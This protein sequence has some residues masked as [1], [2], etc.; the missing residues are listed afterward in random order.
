MIY[1]LQP[2]FRYIH[3]KASNLYDSLQTLRS[4]VL[5]ARSSSSSPS[6][7]RRLRR[8]N[9]SNERNSWVVF[10]ANVACIFDA[11]KSPS[12]RSFSLLAAVGGRRQIMENRFPA[13]NAP[14]Y[15]HIRLIWSQLL[16]S[17]KTLEKVAIAKK[18]LNPTQIND[19]GRYFWILLV[20]RTSLFD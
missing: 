4:V 11:G 19:T 3:Q 2:Y 8:F 17:R 10:M 18:S 15:R 1:V 6:L 5:V 13:K 16:G 14:T 7:P 9:V 12:S 20:V